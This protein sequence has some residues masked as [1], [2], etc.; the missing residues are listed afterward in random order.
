MSSDTQRF[1]SALKA[2]AQD[3]METC[4]NSPRFVPSVVAAILVL[5]VVL[6][7]ARQW[8]Q[9]EYTLALLGWFVVAV[10]VL[11]VLPPLLR[12]LG[13]NLQVI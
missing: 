3:T 2:A 6:L 11:A 13:D 1:S 12:Q 5:Y 7:A 10:V 4:W 8:Q 9:L